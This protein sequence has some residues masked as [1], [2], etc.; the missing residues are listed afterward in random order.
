MPN[1]KNPTANGEPHTRKQPL[2]VNPLFYL[3]PAESPWTGDYKMPDVR[4]SVH[5]C[6]TFF[7]KKLSVSF[8]FEDILTKFGDIVYAYK[9]MPAIHFGLILKNKMAT[10][11]CFRFF[12]YFYLPSSSCCVIATV[13]YFSGYI[14]YYNRLLE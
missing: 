13:L 10:T 7:C 9:K 1:R 2:N 6:I 11:C 3:P 5:V 14:N 4:P 8:N 12:T